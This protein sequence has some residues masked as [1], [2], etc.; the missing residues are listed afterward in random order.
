MVFFQKILVSDDVLAER[1]ASNSG[2]SSEIADLR[3]RVAKLEAI[4]GTGPF[5][6]TRM[7]L[8]PQR[9]GTSN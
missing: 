2:R 5:D 1:L 6:E 9:V 4:L 7:N 3:G 8:D